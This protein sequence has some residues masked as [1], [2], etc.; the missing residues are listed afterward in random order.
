MRNTLI[1][2]V[3]ASLAFPARG[4]EDVPA[5]TPADA[6]LA[7]AGPDWQVWIERIRLPDTRDRG[8]PGARTKFYL[9]E[10]LAKKATLVYDRH[11]PPYYKV[12]TV[13]PDGSVMLTNGT[14]YYW[15]E[16]DGSS[17]GDRPDGTVNDSRVTTNRI[18]IPG[19]VRYYE[20]L[21]ASPTGL[22]M[23]GFSREETQPIY[24]ALLVGRTINSGSLVELTTRN[25]IRR[26]PFLLRN[27]WVVWDDSAY[28]VK[29]KKR[30][31]FPLAEE[32]WNRGPVALDGHV[33]VYYDAKQDAWR[34][35]DL[36]TGRERS[37]RKWTST[38]EWLVAVKGAVGYITRPRPRTLTE[39]GTYE[40]IAVDLSVETGGEKLLHRGPPLLDSSTNGVAPPWR[41]PHFFD[42][43]EGLVVWNGGK[44]ATLGW[45]KPADLRK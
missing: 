12:G 29:T 22:V 14:A 45:V 2:L 40:L 19:S 16:P 24:Y 13:L 1:T 21:S 42:S 30:W 32:A 4:V 8:G 15:C 11:A 20:I 26:S 18:Q 31:R 7:Y 17:V 44:W 6:D 35:F 41:S 36:A 10:P 38:V 5:R 23:K 27:D 33:A 34:A 3:A 9:Q 37:S 25:E 28:N 43:E 39:P